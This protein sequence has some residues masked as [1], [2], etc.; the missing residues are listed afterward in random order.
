MALV[1]FISACALSTYIGSH[2]RREWVNLFVCW[3]LFAF[4][5]YMSLSILVEML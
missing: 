1:L 2:T 3:P 5:V 4:S